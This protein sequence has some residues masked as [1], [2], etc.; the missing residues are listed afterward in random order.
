MISYDPLVKTL[1]KKK[2]DVIELQRMLGKKDDFLRHSLNTR[3]YISMQTLDK[4]CAA[5]NCQPSDVIEYRAG[6]QI[7]KKI[8]KHINVDWEI[9]EST[10]AFKQLTLIEVAV[11][12][13][14]SKSWLL[15]M[16]RR[17]SMKKK[18]LVEICNKYNIDY[19]LMLKDMQ[20]G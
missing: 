2:I 15:N 9:L 19:G 11:E 13:G 1:K 14:R 7:I 3:H 16:K 12:M 8:D 4:I 18:D 10:F 5:L 6:D 17:N 20:N